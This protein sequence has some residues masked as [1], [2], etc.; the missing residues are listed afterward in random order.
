M[1]DWTNDQTVAIARRV[2]A[3]QGASQDRRV[4]A[5]GVLSAAEY[6]MAATLSA[7]ESA[8]VRRVMRPA[9]GANDQRETVERTN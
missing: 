3:E 8:A 1:T 7:E 5:A 9:D 2:I 6:V 4:W